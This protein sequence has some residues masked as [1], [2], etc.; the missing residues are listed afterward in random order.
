VDV[1]MTTVPGTKLQW[2]KS[3]WRMRGD[4]ERERN[5]H[6]RSSPHAWTSW[7]P[8]PTCCTPPSVVRSSCSSHSQP[9]PPPRQPSRDATGLGMCWRGVVEPGPN[10]E[11]WSWWHIVYRKLFPSTKHASWRSPVARSLIQKT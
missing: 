7:R 2:R 4:V 9:R 11:M 10:C 3:C 5:H 8:P 6:C 1:C